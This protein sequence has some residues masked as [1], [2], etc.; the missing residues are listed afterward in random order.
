MSAIAIEAPGLTRQDIVN[1]L[2]GGL[3]KNINHLRGQI[4]GQR[5]LLDDP[6]ETDRDQRA[7]YRTGV[8]HTIERYEH[9][10][11][12]AVSLRDWLGQVTDQESEYVD[13]GSVLLLDEDGTQLIWVLY[14]PKSLRQ[15]EEHYASLEFDELARELGV[16]EV[17]LLASN[18]PIGEWLMGKTLAVNSRVEYQNGEEASRLRFL[19]VL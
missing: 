17:R 19:K 3:D 4:E 8:G 10:M 12:G 2:I 16:D 18:C 5:K 14:D 1:G 13:N 11:K 7:V 9:S 6:S 15:G